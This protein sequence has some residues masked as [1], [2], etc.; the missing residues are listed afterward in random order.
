M[1]PRPMHCQQDIVETL[2]ISKR[3]ARPLCQRDS[4]AGSEM[5][6]A[7]DVIGRASCVLTSAFASFASTMLQTFETESPS[8]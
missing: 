4:A 1:V 2:Q 7:M 5:R 3:Y 8:A 6:G